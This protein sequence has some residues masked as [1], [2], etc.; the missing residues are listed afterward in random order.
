[1]KKLQNLA[2]ATVLGFAVSA[3]LFAADTSWNT[4]NNRSAEWSDAQVN[5]ALDKCN[6]LPENAQAKC[7]VNIR[8]MPP[9]DTHAATSSGQSSY[10]LSSE[11]D[12][13]RDGN[14]RAEQERIAAIEQCQ[15]WHTVDMDR[16]VN[17]L[18]E[19]FGRT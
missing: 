18:T 8:P 11:A 17:T 15:S 2:L 7:I 5:A 9:G 19:R 12:V 10:N 3:P 1:M 6:N 4:E 16:C 14:A 13:V